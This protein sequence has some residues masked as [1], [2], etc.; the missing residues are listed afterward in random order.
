VK[1][2]LF[3]GGAGSAGTL[4]EQISQIVEAEKAG[5]DSLWA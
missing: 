1:I 3:I 2:G 5:F 4:Q